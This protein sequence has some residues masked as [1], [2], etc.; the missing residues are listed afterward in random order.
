MAR[1]EMAQRAF[2]LGTDL[3]V[4]DEIEKGR[5]V[6]GAGATELDHET[7]TSSFGSGR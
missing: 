6:P 4:I 1:A 3:G 2:G 7:S 5:P